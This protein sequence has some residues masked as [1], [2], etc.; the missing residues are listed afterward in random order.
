MPNPTDSPIRPSSETCTPL[1]FGIPSLDELLALDTDEQKKASLNHQT[2]LA[3]VGQDGTGKSVFALHLVSAYLNQ[4]WREAREHCGSV[5]VLY[6]SSDL[7]FK[8]A[9]TV[10]S[11]FGL[12]IPNL[13]YTPFISAPERQRRLSEELTKLRQLGEDQ[14][15]QGGRDYCRIGFE[16]LVPKGPGAK[17]EGGGSSVPDFLAHPRSTQDVPRLGLLDLTDF[18]AGDDWMYLCRLVANQPALASPAPRNLL[19]VDSIEGFETLIGERNSFGERMSR[20]ARIAQLI[21]AAGEDWHLVFLVEEPSPGHRHPEEY[22]ADTVIR[23]R[24]SSKGE[25]V[26]RWVEVE[27][28]RGRAYSPGE[29]PFEIRSGRG[30]ST[31]E[32]EN[33]DD[34]R[35]LVHPEVGR[36]LTGQVPLPEEFGYIQVF[37]SL[38]HLSKQFASGL[39]TKAMIDSHS[40]ARKGKVAPFGIENLDNLLGAESPGDRNSTQ[41]VRTQGLAWGSVNSL[42]GKA[43]TLRKALGKQFLYQAFADLPLVY[44]LVLRLCREWVASPGTQGQ[45]FS[46]WFDERLHQALNDPALTLT[47]PDTVKSKLRAR[48][49]PNDPT[50]RARSHAVDRIARGCHRLKSRADAN[51]QPA[52]LHSRWDEADYYEPIGTPPSIDVSNRSSG[53]DAVEALNSTAQAHQAICLAFAVM[54]A[55]L[56]TLDPVVLVTTQDVSSSDL[57][58]RLVRAQFDRLRSATEDVT[59]LPP[60]ATEQAENLKWHI[61]RLL[62]RHVIVR[63]LEHADISAPQLWHVVQ[64]CVMAAKGM[65]GLNVADATHIEEQPTTGAIRLVISDLQLMR[66][67]Y[68]DFARETL[69]MPMLAFWLQRQ[70]ITSL[71]IDS[72]DSLG[73]AKFGSSGELSMLAARQLRTW[74]VEFFGERR[75]AIT[76][77]PPMAD[78]SHALVRELLRRKSGQPGHPDALP[79]LDVDPHFELYANVERGEAK[80][81]PLRVSLSRDTAAFDEY[82]NDEQRLLSRMFKP[83]GKDDRVIEALGSDEY[84]AIKDC[85]HLPDETRLD[86]THVFAVNGYWA[87]NR[88]NSLEDQARFLNA[89]LK[90]REKP[91]VYELYGSTPVAASPKES[92]RGASAATEPYAARLAAHQ[93]TTLGGKVLYRARIPPGCTSIDRV[94]FMWDFAF[95]LLDDGLVRMYGM[96]L[97]PLLPAQ[98][99]RRANPSSEGVPSNEKEPPIQTWRQLF[100]ACVGHARDTLGTEGRRMVPFTMGRSSPGA[101]LGLLMEVWLSEVLDDLDA[102]EGGPATRAWRLPADARTRLQNLSAEYFKGMR[103]TQETDL[104]QLLGREAHQQGCLKQALADLVAPAESGGE[105]KA[106]ETG[107]DRT[108]VVQLFR[109]WALVHGVYMRRNGGDGLASAVEPSGVEPMRA[110]ASRHYYSTACAA[111]RATKER[112]EQADSALPAYGRVAR[113]PGHFTT[114]G[115]WFLAVAKG[116]RSVRLADRAMDILSSK[117]ANRTRLMMG[118]G[119]PTRPLLAEGASYS[120]VRTALRTIQAGETKTL[121]YEELVKMGAD[122]M[123][124][125]DLAHGGQAATVSGAGSSSYYWFFR[126]GFSSYDSLEPLLR[127]WILRLATWSDQLAQRPSADGP[128]LGFELYDALM[129]A[130]ATHDPVTRDRLRH[131]ATVF[132]ERLDGL[133]LEIDECRASL[134]I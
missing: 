118:L 111:Q 24:R 69:F 2:S 107:L 44:A 71:L 68:P 115:D 102:A 46:A 36:R 47:V 56:G 61:E 101:V 79:D 17:A 103:D 109:A 131:A 105:P 132:G 51:G 96:R 104:E 38:G 13:R 126:S 90:G 120:G 78:R 88:Q 8:S 92:T 14:T 99:E 112:A 53:L 65:L 119:L 72:T 122:F 66:E 10:W 67:I 74:E 85:V 57:V 31:G 75:V 89:S 9:E 62:Q 73:S 80:P 12:G 11:N 37:P 106:P 116:S 20:R 41:P 108:F 22:V 121:Y 113:L 76:V 19:V 35:T 26:R 100:G 60:L 81:V 123:L 97:G 48:F 7:S 3:L 91:D 124:K 42:V 58:N 45:V 134:R 70:N 33:P 23:L 1:S 125:A 15:A 84:D 32:W 21:R 27:K 64:Q 86:H 94:P 54:R 40:E 49:L 98:N 30:T 77:T 133:L 63:R 128:L 117:R 95:L 43:G 39:L 87:L 114:R 59:E 50:R 110:A 93:Q 130:P 34:P 4:V 55:A 28:S 18:S 129:S 5:C 16:H 82:A 25:T 29:H 83:V 52:P 127:N 6:A